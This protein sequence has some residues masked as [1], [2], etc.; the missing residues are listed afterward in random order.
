MIGTSVFTFIG[1]AIIATAILIIFAPNF[2]VLLC[3]PSEALHEGT[4]YV[5]ICGAGMIFIVAYNVIGSVFRG[6]GDSTTPL[7]TVAIACGVNVA[8][9]LLLVA[10]F[11]LGTAGA[12]PAAYAGSYAGAAP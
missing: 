9:D 11:H 2:L 5:R 8:G 7:I 12:A 10:V 6:I 3:T 4:I 1:V